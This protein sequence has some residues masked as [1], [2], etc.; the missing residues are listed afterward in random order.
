MNCATRSVSVSAAVEGPIDEAAARRLI[1]AAGGVP[2]TFYVR[3]GKPSLLGKIDAYNN[4]ARFAPWLVIVDLDRDRECAP[5]ARANWLPDISRYMCFR[6]AVRAIESWFLADRE[7]LA[8]F[9]S[10]PVGRLPNHPET[11]DDPKAEIVRLAKRSRAR[12]I[13]ADIVPRER[14]GRSTGI[15]YASRMIEFASSHW[16]PPEA[17]ENSPSLE[18]ALCCLRGLIQSG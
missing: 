10:V 6:I 8:R 3:G 11:L 5:L 18:R 2:G 4:A 12:R 13:S 1:A 17:G 14:S 7:R 9:L 15:L 16:C